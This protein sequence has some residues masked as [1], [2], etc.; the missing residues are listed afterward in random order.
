M[1][2]LEKQLMC[3]NLK[4]FCAFIMS[5]IIYVICDFFHLYTAGYGRD[6]KK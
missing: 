6:N 5:Y 4:F 2:K 1:M 3:K